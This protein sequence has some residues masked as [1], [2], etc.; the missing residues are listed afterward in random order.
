MIEYKK[1]DSA[2]DISVEYNNSTGNTIEDIIYIKKLIN[3]NNARYNVSVTYEKG[4]LITIKKNN[5]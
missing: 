1:V 4:C 2:N 3:K 5:I